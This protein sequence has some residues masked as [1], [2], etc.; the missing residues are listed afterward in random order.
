MLDNGASVNSVNRSAR[1]R[2][3]TKPDTLVVEVHDRDGNRVGVLSRFPTR[4]LGPAPDTEAYNYYI[5]VL[6]DPLALVD[7]RER[8]I[9]LAHTATPEVRLLDDGFNLRS[10]VRW[11]V[12]D[13]EVTSGDVRA[14]REEY[15]RRR[16]TGSNIWN[17]DYD[18]PMI[19]PERPIADVM[20]DL[21]RA[22]RP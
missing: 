9:A 21:K 6:F 4:R 17:D 15:V 7:A 20:H 14:W 11:H 19:S 1:D 18:G 2:D 13:Q 3:F 22:G 16:S 12:P 5:D 10:I 8:I